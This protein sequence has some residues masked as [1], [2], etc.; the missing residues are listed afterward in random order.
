[1]VYFVY[2]F[3]PCQV[4][5]ELKWVNITILYVCCSSLFIK[6]ISFIYIKYDGADFL[7]RETNLL[8]GPTS[9]RL[10]HDRNNN[11]HDIWALA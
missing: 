8:G 3:F 9:C 7:P 5:S 10:G 6:P 1:M 11:T 4:L 2:L